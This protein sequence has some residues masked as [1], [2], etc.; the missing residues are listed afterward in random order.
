MISWVND[1]GG[2]DNEIT[3]VRFHKLGLVAQMFHTAASPP[4]TYLFLVIG[5]SLLLFEFF[6]AGIGIAGVVGTALLALG[7]YGLGVL[8]VRPWAVALLLFAMF[9]FAIDIHQVQ[10]EALVR[11]FDATTRSLCDFLGLTWSKAL[12]DFS[13]R[14]R[15]AAVK[16][17]SAEQVRRP[18]Y[19]GSGQWRR[20]AGRLARICAFRRLNS[21]SVR[22]ACAARPMP[23][24]S[25]SLSSSPSPS[26]S[27][28]KG[29]AHSPTPRSTTR[30]GLL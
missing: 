22:G 12:R 30:P 4:V 7:S 3:I 9:A 17:A 15:S 11:D 25:S 2:L 8:P 21:E 29:A 18:L 13:D 14:A 23:S 1:D 24:A 5:L 6:T 16:T 10:Y 26:K 20:Y 28:G 27:I 19:D